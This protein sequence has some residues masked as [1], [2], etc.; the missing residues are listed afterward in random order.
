MRRLAPLL[1]PLGLTLPALA[2]GLPVVEDTDRNG[3]WSLVE[4]QA[5]WPELTEDGF[6]VAD[7][8][9]DGQVDPFEL[10]AALDTGLLDPVAG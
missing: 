1:L 7:A 8:N 9:A 3:T 6:G 10:Q 5:A 4:L 2:Q